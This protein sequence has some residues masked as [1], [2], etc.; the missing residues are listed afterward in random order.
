[1]VE[2]RSG[3]STKVAAPVP[4]PAATAS[5]ESV[6]LRAVATVALIATTAVSIVLANRNG[7][8]YGGRSA[9]HVWWY[10]WVT[11]VSTGLGALPMAVVKTANQFYLG[12]S[13][14]MAGGM[15]TAAS[16]AL[17]MEGIELGVDE[18]SPVTPA[19]CVALG[20]A[21][22]VAFIAISQR[23]LDGVGDVH[24]GILEGIDARR[25]RERARRPPRAR[26]PTRSPDMRHKPRAHR[27]PQGLSHQRAQS[28][29]PVAARCRCRCLQHKAQHSAHHGAQPTRRPAILLPCPS[30]LTLPS[31]ARPSQ[32]LRR[33]SSS[34]S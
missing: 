33:S 19:Q 24:L 17:I 7:S 3:T 34:S 10:G 21:I 23:V 2:T 13:N 31:R 5:G 8:L 22:G 28:A 30:P 4:A 9:A 16:A 32:P 15:M 20:A 26:T 29:A 1:M 11:A 12:L 18:R 6:L 14:A 25:V 27:T